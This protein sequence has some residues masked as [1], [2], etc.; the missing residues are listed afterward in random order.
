MHN[1]PFIDTHLEITHCKSK[2]YCSIFIMKRGLPQ[3]KR[4]FSVKK[5]IYTEGSSFSLFYIFT[6]ASLIFT[7]ASFV[8]TMTSFIFTTASFIY[9]TT[10]FIFTTTSFIFTTTSFI[11]TTASSYFL[12]RKRQNTEGSLFCK[13]LKC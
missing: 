6:T 10:S 8:F 5:A 1:V 2:N 13:K 3:Y 4:P 12:L 9:T 7:T 11:F